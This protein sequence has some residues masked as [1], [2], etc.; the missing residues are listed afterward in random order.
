MPNIVAWEGWSRQTYPLTIMDKL[1]ALIFEPTAS[2]L[3][4]QILSPKSVAHISSL[5]NIFITCR[6]H[7]IA[8]IVP[9]M[10]LNISHTLAKLIYFLLSNSP[11]VSWND[12]MSHGQ[13]QYQNG[14]CNS[15]ST[16]AIISSI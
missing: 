4:G 9:S 2:T 7:K 13:G 10:K 14:C 8:P 15:G 16:L 6:R 11:K 1:D 3:L 5:K 12:N